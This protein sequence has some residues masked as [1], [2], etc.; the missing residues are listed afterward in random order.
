MQLSRFS[1]LCLMADPPYSVLTKPVLEK[2][3][4]SMLVIA[5]ERRKRGHAPQP[6]TT[7]SSAPS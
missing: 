3:L 5:D 1:G 2:S 7:Q 6:E 4:K